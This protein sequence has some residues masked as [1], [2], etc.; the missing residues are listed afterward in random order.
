MSPTI[1]L[2]FLRHLHRIFRDEGA[3]IFLLLVPLAYPLLY[4][5]L[6]NNEVV[7]EVPAVGVM[8]HPSGT[9]REYLRRVDASPDVM[10]VW[11]TSSMAE[12]KELMRQGKAR[13]IIY[14]PADFTRRIGR[15]EQA[16]VS[17]LCDMSG[18][19]YYKALVIACTDVSLEME[20]KAAPL[21][22]Y[23]SIAA[24]NPSE[25]FASFLI[26]AVLVLIVQQTLLLGA[27]LLAGTDRDRKRQIS[28]TDN[29]AYKE[30]LSKGEEAQGWDMPSVKT[31]RHKAPSPHNPPVTRSSSPVANLHGQALAYLLIA[32]LTTAYML[33]V[34]PHLFHLPQ[35]ADGWTLLA[36]MLPYL[37][38]CI[39]MAMS[40]STLV[41]NREAVMLMIVF[42]SVPLLFLSGISWPGSSVPTV[43]RVVSW[44]FPS[45]F[46]I[47]GFVR[48]NS[49]GA[50][51]S[52]VWVEYLA[53][54]IQAIVYY[55]IARKRCKVQGAKCKVQGLKFKV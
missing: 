42:T 39:F 32:S 52:D 15:G 55:L 7:R 48:I 28:G 43:W 49:L 24:Y 23:K 40:V 25:G 9:A 13:G 2:P 16:H 21:M 51:L 4:T 37:L 44:L 10:I 18:L 36:F 19:L 45:T 29:T 50:S 12:A 22:E 11:E 26:P 46:G 17:L 6:Y 30:P 5:Y 3:V 34:V 53:L 54:W 1:I 41:P 8:E 33:M 35:L 20:V 27:G 31:S 47:N 14:L 38:A